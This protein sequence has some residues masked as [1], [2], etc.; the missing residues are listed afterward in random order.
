MILPTCPCQCAGSDPETPLFFLTPV[1]PDTNLFGT[2]MCVGMEF[3]KDSAL[4][5][6]L[7]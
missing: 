4:L 3:W 1:L 7:F 5:K 6:K 2:L